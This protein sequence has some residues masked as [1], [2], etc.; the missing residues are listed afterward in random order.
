MRGYVAA[1]Q[2]DRKPLATPIQHAVKITTY[3]LTRSSQLEF[4]ST[5]E[6]LHRYNAAPRGH[7]C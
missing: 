4:Q 1:K 3:T 2:S 5:L 7:A 6:F